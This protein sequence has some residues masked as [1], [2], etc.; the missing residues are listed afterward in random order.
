MTASDGSFGDAAGEMAH[1][2]ASETEVEDPAQQGSSASAGPDDRVAD[3]GG[4]DDTSG[5]SDWV[6]EGGPLEPQDLDEK[7]AESAVPSA[8]EQLAERTLDLQRLQAEYANYRKRV[9]RDRAL[10]AEN[11]TF[12]ALTPIIEVLDNIDRAREAG[13]LDGGFKSVAEQLERAVAASGLHRFAEPGEAFDP[14]RHDALSHMGTDP[15]VEVTTVKLVAKAGYVMGDR[16]VRAA[17]VL[18]V[19]PADD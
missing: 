4:P 7:E 10:V 6:E 16:V 19:D 5:V 12:K 11:A 14:T 2:N 13:E 9:E 3:A 1:E 8:E 17:Q 18:V 15:D